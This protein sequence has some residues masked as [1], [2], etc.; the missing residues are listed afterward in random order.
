MTELSSRQVAGIFVQPQFSDH[1]AQAVATTVAT[2]LN[3]DQWYNIRVDLNLYADTYDVYVD[4][5]Y[6][7]AEGMGLQ[8][9]VFFYKIKLK[10]QKHETHIPSNGDS[11]ATETP[12]EKTEHPAVSDSTT[13]TP[14]RQQTKPA[15]APE[16]Q[17]GMDLPSEDE[18]NL[19]KPMIFFILSVA[20][21]VLSTLFYCQKS[22]SSD[23]ISCIFELIGL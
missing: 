23:L 7:A 1:L 16:R 14:V 12:A 21:L 4:D 22:N 9:E 10:K 11:T 2:D 13:S 8:K 20:A 19:K 17:F 15:L 3:L 5:V 18:E 6:K